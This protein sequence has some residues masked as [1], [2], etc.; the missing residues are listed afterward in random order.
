MSVTAGDAWRVSVV[1]SGAHSGDE[2]DD[3]KRL[4]LRSRG[5]SFK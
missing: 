2:S 4:T 5:I 1:R 3:V